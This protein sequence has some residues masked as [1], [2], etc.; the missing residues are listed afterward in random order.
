MKG[1]GGERKR[2]LRAAAHWAARLGIV[3]L[4]HQKDKKNAVVKLRVRN[5]STRERRMHTEKERVG[6]TQQMDSGRRLRW[7]DNRQLA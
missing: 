6:R 3:L 7:S 1:G 4:L 5:W 2:E